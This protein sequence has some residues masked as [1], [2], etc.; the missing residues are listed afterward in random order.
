MAASKCVFKNALAGADRAYQR[1]WSVLPIDVVKLLLKRTHD[2]ALI[3]FELFGSA[4]TA[5]K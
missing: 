4:M 3:S 2:N 5:V 1:V